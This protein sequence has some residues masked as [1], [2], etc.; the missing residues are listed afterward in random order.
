MFANADGFVNQL[1]LAFVTTVMGIDE[2]TI[3]Y[4][5]MTV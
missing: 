1:W 5:K 4:L 3:S 2:E